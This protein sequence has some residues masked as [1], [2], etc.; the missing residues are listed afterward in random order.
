MPKKQVHIIVRGRVQGV[1]YRACAREEANKLNITGWTKNRE[2]GAVE[3]IAEGE[4]KDLK[5]FVDWCKQG[6]PASNV[7]DIQ[8]SFSEATNEFESFNIKYY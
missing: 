3:I 7:T 4:E 8:S 6:P 1:F 2:D 5:R